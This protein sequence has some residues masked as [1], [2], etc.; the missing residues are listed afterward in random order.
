MAPRPGNQQGVV[1]LEA[2]IGILI[3]SLGVLALVQAEPLTQ[4]QIAHRDIVGIRV[5]FALFRAGNAEFPPHDGDIQSLDFA[6]SMLSGMR[7]SSA[8][9]TQ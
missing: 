6:H 5:R 7:S 2:L 8:R 9:C 1:M 3:F 4:R